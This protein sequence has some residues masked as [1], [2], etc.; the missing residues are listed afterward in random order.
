MGRNIGN[1]IRRPRLPSR[2]A[3]TAQ[4]EQ[5]ESNRTKH[6]GFHDVG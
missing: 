6:I 3:K 1:I 2:K 4:E 5:G